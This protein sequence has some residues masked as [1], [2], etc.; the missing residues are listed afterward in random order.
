MTNSTNEPLGTTTAD[1]D[2]TKVEEV[3]VACAC[4]RDITLDELREAYPERK[5]EILEKFLPD[6]NATL[7]S[8]EITSCLKKVLFLAQ[9]GHE[10]SEF[11]FTA[12][13][14]K[15]GV[16]EKDVYDGYKGRGLVQLTWKKNYTSYGTAVKTDFLDANKVKLE[17]VKWAT[18]P[19]GWYWRNAGSGH[20]I[21]LNPFADQNDIV[22]ISAAINGGFNG[23]EG[24]STSRLKLLKNAVA[25]LHVK[26]C[27]QLEALFSAF[28]EAEK[29]DYDSYPLEKSNAYDVH[30]MSFAWGY[31][32][33]PKSKME[34]VKKDSAQAKIGYS[35]YLE[36]LESHPSKAKLGRFG[37]TRANMK[38]HAEKRVSELP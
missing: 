8:Y 29:F 14:L 11:L 28:P 4:N 22:Y 17:E 25:A 5:K 7:T 20:D 34:G 21:D 13:I 33:D 3:A 32:H 2:H 6:L 36:L 38:K 1:K 31:W 15:K 37:M 12:E 19:A 10:S 18:D 16:D 26:A 27:P 9:V 30:D 35:R 23:Y 24:K